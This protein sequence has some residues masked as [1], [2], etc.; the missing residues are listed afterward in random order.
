MKTYIN[1]IQYNAAQYSTCAHK[2]NRR[3]EKKFR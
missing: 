1:E 2:N 3:V